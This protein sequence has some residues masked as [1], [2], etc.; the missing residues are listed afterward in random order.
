MS[1]LLKLEIHGHT[2][3]IT[4]D[5]P[6]ANTWTKES[7]QALPKIV[8]TL[9]ENKEIY[10][11]IITGAGKK[12]FC[13]GADLNMFADGDKGNAAVIALLFGEAFEALSHFRG[14]S[15]AAINGWAMGGGLEAALACDTRIAEEQVNMALPEASVGLLPAGHGTQ[16][17]PHLIGEGWAKRMI[18]CGE[19]LNAEQALRIGLVEEVVETGKALETA[20]ALAAQVEKQSPSSVATCK[21]LIQLGRDKPMDGSLAMEREGFVALFDREDQK[22]GTTAFLEKRKPVWK[23]A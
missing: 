21:T 8:H 18:L 10:C 15:I 5:N 17:L 22:E 2:A 23:N 12:F 13:A 1:E 14:V 11:L 7:L 9:N 16:I 6:G 19:R 4:M 3:I 20:L